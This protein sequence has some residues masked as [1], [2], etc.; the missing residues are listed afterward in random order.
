MKPKPFASLNHFTLPVVRIPAPDVRSPN[1]VLARRSILFT[2]TP[3][4]RGVENSKAG[5]R[6]PAGPASDAAK[7]RER[8][9]SVNSHL[10]GTSLA[11]LLDSG[12]EVLRLAKTARGNTLVLIVAKRN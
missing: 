2:T 1:D 10:C 5:P 11:E 9:K 12:H 6:E 3:C 8:G 4:D 7:L